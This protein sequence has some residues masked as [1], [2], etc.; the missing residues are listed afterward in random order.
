MSLECLANNLLELHLWDGVVDHLYLAQVLKGVHFLSVLG[1]CEQ[2]ASIE[3]GG[4][5]NTGTIW[6][7]Y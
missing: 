7:Q 4:L 3:P 5:H 1:P 6:V 2:C